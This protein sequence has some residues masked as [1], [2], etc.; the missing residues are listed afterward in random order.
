MRNVKLF[1]KS[2]I[3]ESLLLI[4]LI[5]GCNHKKKSD[6]S[7]KPASQ[8]KTITTA[9]QSQAP[10]TLTKKERQQSWKLLFDGQ[11]TN[12]WRKVWGDKFPKED[13]KVENGKLIVYPSEGKQGPNGKQ[14]GGGGS[15][16]TK[17]EYSNFI[18]KLDFKLTKGANSGIKYFLV[19]NPHYFKDDP[20]LSKT[21]GIGLE[22]QVLDDKHNPDAHRGVNGNRTC[23]SLYDMIPASKDK[24][25]NPPGQWNHA[26]IVSKGHHVEHWLNGEKVME[27]ERGSDAFNALVDNSKYKI[28]E[29]FGLAPKGHIELQD[30]GT[31]VSFKNIKVKVLKP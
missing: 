23:A 30:H 21:M 25:L 2:T 29:N 28:Y 18:F 9:N 17:K 22:Y 19:E 4:L 10:N 20:N 15:I 26:K 14:G 6:V 24:K 16:V 12:H 7:T 3:F 31:K 5:A 11:S 27:Y 1:N 8:M 13:W